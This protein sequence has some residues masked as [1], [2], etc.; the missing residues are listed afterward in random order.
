MHSFE[1]FSCSAGSQCTL[2]L[3]TQMHLRWCASLNS[4]LFHLLSVLQNK[5]YLKSLSMFLHYSGHCC[6]G[7]VNYVRYV[8]A[9][10]KCDHL[11]PMSYTGI[12]PRTFLVAVWLAANEKT[13]SLPNSKC[14]KALFLP[15]VGIWQ[16][17][18][19]GMRTRK[20]AVAQKNPQQKKIKRTGG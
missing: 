4:F 19:A 14:Y 10:W 17:T 9:Y 1:T 15:A 16:T 11:S 20:L 8:Y 12:C 5:S 6:F 7:C 13:G 3:Q 18:A 2:G